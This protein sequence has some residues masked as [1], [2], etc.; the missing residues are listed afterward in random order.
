MRRILPIFLLFLL[1][2]AALSATFTVTNCAA[3]IS[4]VGSL[5]WALDEARKVSLPE[6]SYVD[7]NIPTTDAGYSTITAEGSV[8]GFWRIQPEDASPYDLNRDSIAVRGSTQTSNQGDTNPYGPE[9]EI[10][11]TNLSASN[12][13]FVINANNE[14]T[15]EGMILCNSKTNAIYIS[16]GN[17]QHIFGCYIGTDATGEAARAN[18]GTGI[19]LDRSGNTVI[20]GDSNSLRNIIS[21][22]AQNGIELSNSTATQV[23]NNYIGTNRTGSRGLPNAQSGVALTN[24]AGLN[25]ANFIGS[26]SDAGRNIISGNAQYGIEINSAFINQV[27]NNYIGTDTTEAGNLGNTS[28]GIYLHNGARSQYI[29][30]RNIIAFNSGDGVRIDG[31]TTYS[32]TL[33]QNSFFSNTGKGI[34]LTSSGNSNIQVPTIATSEYFSSFGLLG[35]LYV[36]GGG[37]ASAIIELM[38]VATPETET[39][40][41]GKTTLGFAEA[42]ANGNWFAY[43]LT[44]EAQ[45]GDKITALATD[46]NG[47]TSEFAQNLSTV[48]GTV[49]YRPDG[50]I[51]LASDGTDYIGE[52]VFNTTGSNQT[53]SKNIFNTQAAIYYIKVKNAGNISPDSVRITG[54]GDTADWQIK[55]YDAKTEGNDITTQVTGSG[56]ITSSILAS[57]SFE[58]RAEV[59]STGS[60]LSTKEVFVT[61]ASDSNTSRLDVVKAVTVATPATPTDAY[62]FV[63]SAP[64]SAEAGK[65]FQIT[66]TARN[67]A[68]QITTEVVGKTHL[69]VDS[70]T[71]SV[72]SLDASAFSQEGIWS[73]MISLSNVGTR[74]LYVKND[75]I[76]STATAVI[77]VVVPP[78]ILSGGLNRFG[79]NPYNPTS[80]QPAVFWYWLNE[81]KT[82]SIFIFD[83]QG[84]LLWK[85][86]YIAGSQGGRSGVN[87]ITWD[88]K[89]NFGEILPNG[90]YFFRIVQGSKIVYKS[91]LIILK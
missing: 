84:S 49:I 82:T 40:G 10:D 90:I 21:G 26:S 14:C 39:A 33:T 38:K 58:C 61:L 77:E 78:E 60:T 15:L 81:D 7:F 13:L 17:E 63:I 4:Q 87:T 79:P 30:S 56:Y 19:L 62:H 88:G 71:V 16:L 45:P 6:I 67:A 51:G 22:N 20:G 57:G 74:T 69:T 55:Y 2:A 32:N 83:M 72:T 5:A 53:K 91:K 18:A 25:G 47:N 86:T 8:V 42:D 75:Y 59:I 12:P 1:S 66:I 11:G 65:E 48:V 31:S 54:T 52:N 68:G 35:L 36:Q 64:L 24:N 80:G 85:Q 27:L 9:I 73:G 76:N 3:S 34:A 70:G 44:G 46:R 41:E 50:M 89:N 28:H 23:L 43:L 29:A 37:P